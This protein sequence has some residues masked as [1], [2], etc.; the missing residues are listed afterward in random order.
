M[1]PDAAQRIGRHAAVAR[2]VVEDERRTGRFR[3]GELRGTAD[4]GRKVAC[5]ESCVGTDFDEGTGT[6]AGFDGPEARGRLGEVER[7]AG[8]SLSEG[9]LEV[10]GRGVAGLGEGRVE[11]LMC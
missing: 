11:A 7:V 4:A 6:E 3:L 10:G 9:K 8:G 1:P 5:V 2:P